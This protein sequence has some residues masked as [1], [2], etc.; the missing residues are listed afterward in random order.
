MIKESLTAGNLRQRRRT[1][2]R[3][4][5]R[6]SRGKGFWY[7]A[8]LVLLVLVAVSAFA[9]LWFTKELIARPK[10]FAAYWLTVVVL[11]VALLV[12]GVMVMCHVRREY[13]EL[14]RELK[15]RLGTRIESQRHRKRP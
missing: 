2:Q 9:G 14:R 15:Q 7:K 8:S 1:A 13:R 5:L 6:A 3:G 10:L 11:A 4:F 12:S